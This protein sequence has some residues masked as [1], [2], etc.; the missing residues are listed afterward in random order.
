MDAVERVGGRCK[1]EEQAG[2]PIA[3]LRRCL[4]DEGHKGHCCFP[5][6]G[7]KKRFAQSA[8]PSVVRISGKSIRRKGA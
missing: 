4:L 1:I 5:E 2:W 8:I 6:S 3:T 7:E